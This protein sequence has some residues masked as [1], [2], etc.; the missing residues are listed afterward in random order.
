M[1]DYQTIKFEQ[2]GASLDI[3]ISQK[4]KTAWLTKEDMSLLFERDRTV[5]S[6]HIRNIFK[7]GKLEE[8]VSCAKIA[9]QVGGQTHHV[10]FYNLEVVV[11]V[12]YRIKSKNAL[13][14]QNFIKD[15][16]DGLNKKLDNTI[17]IYNNG[18]ISLPVSISPSEETVWLNKEQLILLFDTTRQNVEYHINNIYGE[19]EL[20]EVA[21]RKE[22]LQVQME[23]DRKVARLLSFY[24]LDL[25]ISLGY[26]IN[27]KNGIDFR[28]WATNVLKEYLL[29]GYVVNEER[30]LVTNDN[31]LN[32]IHKV[33]NIDK[34]LSKIE[35][36]NCVEKEKIFF[37]GEYYDARSFLKS[38]FSSAKE[39]ILLI[40][41]Y[42]DL[43]TLDYLVG[44][45]SDVSITLFVSSHSKI[46][47]ND[48]ES[49]NKQY[50]GLSVVVNDSFHDR[51]IIIDNAQ[52]Y[53][54]GAS[55]NYAGK[56]TFAVTK[57]ED[58]SFI[59]SIE[60]RLFK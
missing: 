41:S 10:V 47:N 3:N 32:L 24:N 33:D 58:A 46:T 13:L 52:I 45:A 29:R 44:K 38:I 55:L 30:T 54:L 53:H 9:R 31:Y 57:M 1:E 36:N 2:N 37:D 20:E 11:L 5:I 59:V 6:R 26:R 34:R 23:G 43:K 4:E 40:D 22:Y 21:T 56:R 39:N 60:N 8:N 27:T 17:I 18:N 48:I 28:R 15:Y 19:G 16:F 42:S 7:E 51:F 49:F 14:L 12:G 50:G 25:I 35:T